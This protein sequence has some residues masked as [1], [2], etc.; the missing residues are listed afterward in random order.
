[1]GGMGARVIGAGGEVV[2]IAVRD[3]DD[4]LVDDVLVGTRGTGVSRSRR[5]RRE[6]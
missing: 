3:F 1:M 4:G 5:L 2:Y 6:E